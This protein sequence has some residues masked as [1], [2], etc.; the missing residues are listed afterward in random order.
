ML[1]LAP[2][3]SIFG[4][5]GAPD[6]VSLNGG[7]SFSQMSPSGQDCLVIEEVHFVNLKISE[8]SERQSAISLLLTSYDK[9]HQII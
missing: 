7:C 6:C 3:L 2:L 8:S 1:F 9:G 5:A 4:F